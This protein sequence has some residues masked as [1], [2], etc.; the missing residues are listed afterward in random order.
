MKNVVFIAFLR[1]PIAHGNSVHRCGAGSGD[2]MKDI[3]VQVY[4]AAVSRGDAVNIVCS[5]RHIMNDIAVNVFI[6]I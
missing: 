5:S 2:I 4:A 3:G 6:L 1:G